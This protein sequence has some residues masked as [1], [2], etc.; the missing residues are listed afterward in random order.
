M[1]YKTVTIFPRPRGWL[2]TRAM[3]SAHK[4]LNGRIVDQQA[5]NL[6]HS[7][8]C[9]CA[10]TFPAW[11]KHIR[12]LGKQSNTSRTSVN[13]WYTRI[14]HARKQEQTTS[15]FTHHSQQS[16]MLLQ[17]K[18][19]VPIIHEA[20]CFIIPASQ[21]YSTV[22]RNQSSLRGQAATSQKHANPD[23][24]VLQAHPLWPLWSSIRL[25]AHIHNSDHSS[26]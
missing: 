11:Q 16:K 25:G 9:I 15:N 24:N 1:V 8:G 21:V 10:C 2:S 20:N 3:I 4:I 14:K 22:R 26:S 12:L 23:R 17:F 6:P 18:R 5:Y 13:F 7:D 19:S